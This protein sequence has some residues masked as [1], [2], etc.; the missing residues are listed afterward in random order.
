MHMPKHET[1]NEQL[2]PLN[3][4]FKLGSRIT[5]EQ[6]RFLDV[7][8]FLVFEQV[9]K[10]DEVNTVTS[11]IE[12]IGNEWSQAEKRM[13]NGVPLFRGKD[14]TG[15]PFIQRLSFTSMYSTAIREVLHDERFEPIRG[16]IGENARVGDQEKDGP[17]VSRYINCKGSVYP[18]L[19]WHTDGIRDVF[20]GR[21]PTQ[22]LNVGL[23]FDE[24]GEDDG[25]L[26]LIPGTHNQGFW[27]TVFRKAHFVSHNVDPNEIAV[28]TK[29]G[30][31]TI[32]DGRLWHRVQKSNRTGAESLRRVM[33]V[34]YLTDEYQPKNDNSPTPLYHYLSI[35][36]CWF[37][38]NFR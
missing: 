28:L 12:R 14:H 15:T 3:T 16:L 5:D 10:T 6:A 36:M 27:D 2:P 23:H 1:S 33:Y 17:V 8:G 7:H 21:M 32:H 30:D 29:P 20:Y 4:R 25:G 26:R 11:E 18:K 24:C 9:L 38:R 13:V 34:P 22:M 19:G 35:F 37:K 31:L